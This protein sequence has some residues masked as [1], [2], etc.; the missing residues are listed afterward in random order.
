M[1]WENQIIANFR[2]KITE[3]AYET[4]R[5]LIISDMM[6]MHKVWLDA[7]VILFPKL[8][9]IFDFWRQKSTKMLSTKLIYL[10]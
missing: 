2:N 7:F 5:I 6:A 9:M 3:V 8:K 1:G 10:L 4:L